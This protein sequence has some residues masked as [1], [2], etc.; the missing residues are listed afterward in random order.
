M[1]LQFN[2]HLARQEGWPARGQLIDP[3][4]VIS[5]ENFLNLKQ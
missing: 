3:A 4:I 1:R 2:T 5:K